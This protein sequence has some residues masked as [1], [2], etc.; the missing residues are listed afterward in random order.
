MRDPILYRIKRA[1]ITEQVTIGV[2]T[3]CMIWPHCIGDAIEGDDAF[4]TVH[5]RIPRSST[6]L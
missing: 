3:Q 5:P 4:S 6:Y 2:S 1:H